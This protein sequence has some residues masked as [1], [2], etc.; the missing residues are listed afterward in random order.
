MNTTIEFHHQ[1]WHRATLRFTAVL[2]FVLGSA[3]T[4]AALFE[5]PIRENQ[6]TPL[7]ALIVFSWS[8]FAFT[9][10]ARKIPT[11]SF[12]ASLSG[13][14]VMSA[15]AP[16]AHIPWN[17]VAEVQGNSV[18]TG[19]GFIRTLQSSKK[20]HFCNWHGEADALV[21]YSIQQCIAHNGP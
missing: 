14:D 4:Y 21:D 11:H 10:L 1:W 19:M 3:C 17:Q 12:R 7:I 20:F 18:F 6:W 9:L 16:I 8:T 5:P 13:V 15:Q 2:S